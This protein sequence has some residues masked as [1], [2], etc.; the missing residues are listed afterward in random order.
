MDVAALAEDRTRAQESDAGDDLGGDAGRVDP[1]S[2]GWHEPKAGEH[3]GAD[4]DERH[5]LEAGRVASIL[6]LDPKH[7]AEDE[8]DEEAYAELDVVVV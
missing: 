4:R 5:R 8:R 2:G 3:A 1:R 6:A 7:E